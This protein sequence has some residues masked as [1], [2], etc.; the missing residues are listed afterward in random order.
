MYIYVCVLVSMGACVGM[1]HLYMFVC[2]CVHVA[3]CLCIYF[4]VWYVYM[5][6]FVSFV[7][8]SMV[9][10]LFNTPKGFLLLLICLLI[11]CLSLFALL[12]KK[13]L[14]QTGWFINSKTSLLTDLKPG[15]WDQGPS[16]IRLGPPSPMQ[17]SAWI[18]RWWERPVTPVEPLL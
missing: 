9:W 1:N 5:I 3:V 18:L 8:M 17:A 14:P 12:L 2:V 13:N 4:Y 11:N 6:M 10:C 7:C 16:L 15:R